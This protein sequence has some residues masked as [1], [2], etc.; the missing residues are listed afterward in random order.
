MVKGK[1][2][3]TEEQQ[4][5]VLHEK[6]HARVSAV[7][8]SGKTTAMVA[9][10]C[11]L[12]EQGMHPDLIR[13]LMFNRSAS[14]A[15]TGKLSRAL[16]GT[17]M[18]VPAVNTFHALGLRLVRSFTRRGAL[19]AYTLLTKE[20]ELE[21]LAREAIKSYL[22]DHGGDESWLTKEYMEG[23]ITFIELV[24]ADT[25]PAP[26][27][28]DLYQIDDEFRHFIGVYTIFEQMRMSAGVRFFSDLVREPVLAMQTDQDLARWVGNRVDYIIVDEYQDINEVQQQLLRFIAGSRAEVMVVGDVDQCIYEWRGARPEYIVSR[29][30]RDFSDGV[31][32]S[33]SYTFRYGHRLS[34]AANYLISNN[35][36]R[37]RKLCLSHAGTPDTR[38]EWHRERDPHPLPAILADWQ[39]E[40]R[41]LREAVVLVR[42]YA[43]SVPVELTL[44]EHAI[45]YRLIGHDSVFHCPEIRA[46]LG[47]LYLCRDGLAKVEDRAEAIAMVMAML[48]N[49]HLWLNQEAN[50]RL[51][52]A[53]VKNTH[54][55][56]PLIRERSR[57]AK[58]PFLAGRM[59]DLAQVWEGLSHRSPADKATVVLEKIIDDTGLFA[60]YKR[61]S[62]IEG[63]ANKIRTCRAF[64]RFARRRDQNI[65]SFL[66]DV[67]QLRQAN[68]SDQ[69]DY[70]LITSIHRAKGLEW[71]LVIL[72]GLEDGAVPYRREDDEEGGAGIEDE[73]RLMYVGMTRAIEKL[74]LL[75]AS[76]SRFEKRNRAGDSRCPFS[77]EDK[78]F[79]ASCFLYEANLRL[80]DQ[81]G[82]RI[83]RPAADGSSLKFQNIGIARRY[84]R[85]IN[86][87]IP[88]G[89]GGKNRQ[90]RQNRIRK[91]STWLTMKEL[92]KGQ[93]VYH[94]TLGTGTVKSIGDVQGIVTV[95][96]ADFGL[97]NLV[98]NLAKLRPVGGEELK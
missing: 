87:D 38:L 80:S 48:T 10:V 31:S 50:R 98:I 94:K 42:L 26:D 51:A 71:P 78:R 54:L 34:L 9:R 40:H 95:Q 12:L 30:G 23:V 25:R 61:F 47:Y 82:G 29:F 39:K 58:T 46:L 8:G 85:E 72:P 81:L 1:M 41:S 4:Q 5:I 21:K 22:A 37:D 62:S 93:V 20:Y 83:A 13:V 11:H 76:D 15:F 88:L 24:K 18:A 3:L 56:A 14:K 57:Q 49:P 44:L 79:P 77:T 96:F 17:S 43:I 67:E 19:P 97:Q 59:Q 73:R 92:H 36:M 35:R 91:K 28:F 7:A 27:L 65:S 6:G 84:L 45:P 16:A 33:L 32:Y 68:G 86:V 70:L 69:D 63:A 74:C 90:K 55:A 53:I 2:R 75:H 89:S 52:T 60:F 66:A 64:I